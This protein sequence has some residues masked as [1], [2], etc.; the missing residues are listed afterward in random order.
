MLQ[1]RQQRLLDALLPAARGE[2]E[3]RA[4]SSARQ[5]LRKQLREG[6]LDEREVTLDLTTPQSTPELMTPPGMEEMASQLQGLFAGLQQGRRRSERLPVKEALKRLEA[7]EGQR[8]QRQTA[9]AEEKVGSG[10]PGDRGGHASRAA[11]FGSGR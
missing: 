5:L 7:E 6:A 8:R 1:F 3:S 9:E 4:D 2:T 10:Q 11:G